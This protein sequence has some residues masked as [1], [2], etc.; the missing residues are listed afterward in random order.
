MEAHFYNPANDSLEERARAYSC[1]YREWQN[2]EA[3]FKYHDQLGWE[4]KLG[5]REELL[6]AKEIIINTLDKA[7]A[8]FSHQDIKNISNRKLIAANELEYINTTHPTSKSIEASVIEDRKKEIEE[9]R[10]NQATGKS[11]D[12][13]LGKDI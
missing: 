6:A 8:S 2:L 13:S 5:S 11:N 1:V 4:D 7:V 9:I 3:S 10:K 12:K